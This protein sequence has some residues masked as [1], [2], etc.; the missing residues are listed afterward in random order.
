MLIRDK[1][2]SYAAAHKEVLPSVEHRRHKRLNNRAETSHQPTRQ[3]ER[4]MRRFTS[5]GHAQ[6]FLAAYGPI[7]EHCCPRRHRLKAADYRRERGRRFQVWTEV[8]SLQ[9]AA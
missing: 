6:R 4:T 8:T 3:R 2:S 9:V 7:R 1:L 5:P